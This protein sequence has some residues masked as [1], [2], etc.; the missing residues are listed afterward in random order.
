MSIKRTLLLGLAFLCM[1]LTAVWLWSTLPVETKVGMQDPAVK[2]LNYKLGLTK[3]PLRSIFVEHNGLNLHAVLAEKAEAQT[4]VF[5]HGF[6]SFWYSFAR[7]LEF[8]HDDYQLVAI[9]GL[10]VN[11]SDA[12]NEHSPYKLDQM[13]DH[14]LALM[15]SLNVEQF[16][17]IG[18][19]WGSAMALGLAQKYPNRVLSVTGISSPPQNVMLQM[20]VDDV[21]SREKYAYVKKLKSANPFL[22]MLFS[23]AE[24]VYEGAYKPLL[25]RKLITSQEAV[26]FS[27]ATENVKR[28]D[29]HINWYRANAPALN[30]IEANDY[31]PQKEHK[32][33]QPTLLVWGEKDFVFS[34][35]YLDIV[36]SSGVNV[37][38]L[39]LT[40]SGHWPHVEDH[41]QVNQAILRL[42]RQAYRRR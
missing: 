5:V 15:D 13:S 9:D 7:Q 42:I 24:K 14:L 6:P 31:W 37:D 8:F 2:H 4:L 30:E 35:G 20:L 38:V 26:L 16:H 19:D 22:L 34:P 39:R 41:E 18:H 10:G 29:A 33:V 3:K 32:L 28:L 25:E 11:Y 17:L 12:P 40:E 36:S 23:A 1:S 21:E 27:Q